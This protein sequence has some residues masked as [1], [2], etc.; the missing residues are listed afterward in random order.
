MRCVYFI[1]QEKKRIIPNVNISAKEKYSKIVFSLVFS[2]K[3]FLRTLTLISAEINI[4]VLIPK[5]ITNADKNPK[6]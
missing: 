6:K 3:V 4:I 2:F 5:L 1:P